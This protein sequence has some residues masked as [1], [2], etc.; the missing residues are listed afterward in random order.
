MHLTEFAY[1]ATGPFAFPR[2]TRAKYITEAFTLARKNPNI[3][4]ILYFGLMQ[5]PEIQWNTGLLRPDGTPTHRSIA[6]R[7]W[8][9]REQRAGRLRPD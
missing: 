8:V 5:N 4:Q 3:S 1:F 9:E 7:D 6:L 2:A